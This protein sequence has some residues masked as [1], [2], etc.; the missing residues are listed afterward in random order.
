MRHVTAA[1]GFVLFV[2]VD[3]LT[4]TPRVTRHHFKAQENRSW[5]WISVFLRLSHFISLCVFICCKTRCDA[6]EVLLSCKEYLLSHLVRN[7]CLHLHYMYLLSRGI[8]VLSQESCA[9]QYFGWAM[10][11]FI[12]L[13]SG[14]NGLHTTPCKTAVLGSLYNELNP[15]PCL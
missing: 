3:L 4:L 10:W 1:C 9:G 2:K 7:I 13:L 5:L 11:L 15:V 14:N 8:L 12:I 6:S